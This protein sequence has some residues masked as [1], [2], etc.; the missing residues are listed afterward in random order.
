[1]AEAP[2]PPELRGPVEAA[3]THRLEVEMAEAAEA[4]GATDPAAYAPVRAVARAASDEGV[5]LTSQRAAAAL[6]RAVA[7]AVDEAVTHVTDHRVSSAIGMVALTLELGLGADLGVAQERIYEALRE[8]G[9]GP[10]DRRRLA[11]LA[12]ALGLATPPPI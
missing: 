1:V 5:H 4:D 2:L 9:L 6:A 12:D 10:D 3:L 11:G 8:D 7:R